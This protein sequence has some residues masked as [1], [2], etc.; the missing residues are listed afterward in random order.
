MDNVQEECTDLLLRIYIILQK[1]DDIM[2]DL[3]G[4]RFGELTVFI[5]SKKGFY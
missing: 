1:G 4:K 3:T 5:N 2:E